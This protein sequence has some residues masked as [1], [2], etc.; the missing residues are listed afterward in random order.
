MTPLRQRMLEDMQVRNLSPHTQASY[1]QQV[2]Q[3]ARYFG[4]SPED[5][6]PEDI[7]TYQ[8]YLT[9]E[10]NLAPVSILIAVAAIRFLYKV[11]LKRNWVFEEVIPTCK[12]PQKLP[13]VLSPEEVL[14]LLDHVRTL[15]QRTILTVKSLSIPTP[16]S[17]PIA[18]P[19][20]GCRRLI[21]V[22]HRRDRARSAALQ[23]VARSG[24][25]GRSL[26][27]TWGKPVRRKISPVRS[28]VAERL[29]E[30]R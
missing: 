11:T 12:K 18:T 17:R 3:F 6:G 4:K 21:H 20:G 9:N 28:R 26:C 23:G 16:I 24:G 27:M 8:V 1:C 13:E 14:H 7:R 5:L 25:R 2:S 15:K 10:R 30:V 19:V 22:L 29:P